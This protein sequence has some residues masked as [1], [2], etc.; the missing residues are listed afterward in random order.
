MGKREKIKKTDEVAKGPPVVDPKGK[1]NESKHKAD[2]ETKKGRNFAIDLSEYLKTWRNDKTQWK[3]NKV[4]QAW[5]LDNCFSKDLVDKQLFHDLLPYI[6]TVMGQAKVRLTERADKIIKS[7]VEESENTAIKRARKI[8]DQF[9]KS[10]K[11]DDSGQSHNTA[12][13]P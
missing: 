5:A 4:L 8:L 11:S 6:G 1:A 13:S 12:A 3:F 9:R 7:E 10:T 2:L